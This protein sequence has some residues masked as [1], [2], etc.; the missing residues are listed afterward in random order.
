MESGHVALWRDSGETHLLNAGPDLCTMRQHSI[1]KHIV[2]TGGKE[3][4]LKLFDI[5]KQQSIFEEKN[6]PHDWLELRV[7]IWVTDTCFL[8][9]NSVASCSKYGHVS[10]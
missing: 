1:D 7:P 10:D 3:N 6:V 8:P 2:A 5:E 4:K 9:D